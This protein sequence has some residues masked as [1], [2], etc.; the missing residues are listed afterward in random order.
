[1]RVE[2]APRRRCTVPGDDLPAVAARRAA[3]C[4]R[5][6]TT[7]AARSGRSPRSSG[8]RTGSVFS[9]A[10]RHASAVAVDGDRDR[11]A[12]ARADQLR[13][14]RRTS[15]RRVPS[16]ATTRSPTGSPAAAAGVSVSTSP[17]FVRRVLRRRAGRV[18][19]EED[20]ERDED[21][22]ER[23]GGDDGDALPRRL[24][25][26]RVGA[27]ALVD[28]AQRAVRRTGGRRSSASPPRPRSR[29]SGSAC[30]RRGEVLG[31]ER[32][33]ARAGRRARGPAPRAAPAP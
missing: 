22:R 29:S 30:A 18:D 6:G 15:S 17:T 10:E 11:P 2:A 32:R 16:T 5:A 25:P 7:R 20:D 23:A 21:V 4:G 27:G 19:G 26:V 28:L 14:A 13:D 9:R 12:V 8:R 31:L 24:A 33:G 3:R 1:M